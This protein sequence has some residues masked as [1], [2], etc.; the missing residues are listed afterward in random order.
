VIDQEAF[1]G[2]AE[3]VD[4]MKAVDHLYRLGGSLANA[5]GVQV[6]AIAADDGA[7]RMLR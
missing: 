2:L 7:R 3:V 4:E 6:A 1:Q 5:V